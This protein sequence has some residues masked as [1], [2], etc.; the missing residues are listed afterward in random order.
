MSD[1]QVNIENKKTVLSPQLQDLAERMGLRGGWVVLRQV[2]NE[3]ADRYDRTDFSFD[4]DV[5][6]PWE[7]QPVNVVS[8]RYAGGPKDGQVEM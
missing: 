3:H 2:W 4:G 6:A 5:W 1:K 7:D 8:I